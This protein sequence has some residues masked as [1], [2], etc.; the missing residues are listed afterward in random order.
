MKMS[1]HSRQLYNLLLLCFV[2]CLA[3]ASYA[4]N[5][6][7]APEENFFSVTI[8]DGKLVRLSKN[9]KNTYKDGELYLAFEITAQHNAAGGYQTTKGQVLPINKTYKD[10]FG[11]FEN[12]YYGS[13]MDVPK[14]ERKQHVTLE[15]GSVPIISV[16]G[17]NEQC[18]QLGTGTTVIENLFE[19][20]ILTWAEDAP[21]INWFEFVGSG[22]VFDKREKSLQI[23]CTG[24]PPPGKKWATV[25]P[26]FTEYECTGQSKGFVIQGI[27]R[28][29][30]FIQ[31]TRNRQRDCVHPVA[32]DTSEKDKILSVTLQGPEWQ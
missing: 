5:K 3:D 10:D 11:I 18:K 2:F 28:E 26:L 27:G 20:W 31:S 30:A 7:K 16:H 23:T 9:L 12:D 6:L 21:G 19:I 8:N 24:Y 29:H 15:H 14:N 25:K 22:D 4:G 1:H 13:A 17:L 32:V